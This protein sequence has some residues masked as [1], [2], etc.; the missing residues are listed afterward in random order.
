MNNPLMMMIQ[1]ARGGGNPIQIISQMAGGNPIMGQGLRMI[2][3][4][5]P[6]QIRQMAENMASE[7]GTT[8]EDVLRGLGLR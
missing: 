1:A 2:Q 7:R 8:A 4:K 6:D 3:G 5:S